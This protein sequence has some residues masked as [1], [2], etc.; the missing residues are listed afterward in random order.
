MRPPLIA[1]PPS[2][3]RRRVPSLPSQ[4]CRTDHAFS[5]ARFLPCCHSLLRA[6]CLP[7][8]AHCFV[9]IN[10]L[11]PITMWLDLSSSPRSALRVVLVLFF[12]LLVS[13]VG[14][15]MSPPE[16]TLACNGLARMSF[17]LKDLV[18]LVALKRNP[19]PFQVTFRP[20]RMNSPVTVLIS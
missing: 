15:A 10:I 3:H 14:A 2:H 1:L 18:N 19:G 6:V 17:D 8:S 12:G 9:I 20:T 13:L 5:V 11:L 16:I 4:R 7:S